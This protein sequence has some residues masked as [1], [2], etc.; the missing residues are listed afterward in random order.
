MS[1]SHAASVASVVRAG[2]DLAHIRAQ[3]PIL[4]QRI[5]SKPLVY[6]DNAASVQ[7]PKAVIDAI[8]EC[9]GSSPRRSR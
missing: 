5:H 8:S 3:F 4:R 6:L 1:T 2:L 7:K 9:S